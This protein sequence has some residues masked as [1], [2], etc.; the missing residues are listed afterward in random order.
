M[1]LAG[2]EAFLQLAEHLVFVT[3]RIDQALATPP[4]APEMAL[5]RSVAR[6][7]STVFFRDAGDR[8]QQVAVDIVEDAVH[9]LLGLRTHILPREHVAKVFILA[10]VLHFHLYAQLIER[11]AKIQDLGAKSLH[12]QI[13]F[14][15]M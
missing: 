4:A 11:S 13:L 3:Q 12:I 7:S 9:D 15:A 14:R 5:R 6:T 8:G 1:N 2:F 10:G